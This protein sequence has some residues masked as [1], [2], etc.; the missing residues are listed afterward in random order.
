LTRICALPSGENGSPLIGQTVV[1]GAIWG[2]LNTCYK[3]RTI[4]R[5]ASIPRVDSLV[6]KKADLGAWIQILHEMSVS[7]IKVC[8]HQPGGV[9]ANMPLSNWIEIGLAGASGS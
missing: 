7:P 3:P 1:I 6:G 4:L 5:A 9:R 2:G 8:S